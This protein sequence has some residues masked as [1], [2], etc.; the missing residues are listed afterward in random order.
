MQWFKD[1]LSNEK[2]FSASL[3]VSFVIHAA[4][5]LVFLQSGKVIVPANKPLV[6]DFSIGSKIHTYSRTYEKAAADMPKLNKQ[7]VR[8]SRPVPVPRTEEQAGHKQTMPVETN[9]IAAAPER[10]SREVVKKDA[11]HANAD[12]VKTAVVGT[13]TASGVNEARA[14]YLKEHFAYIRDLIMKSISYPRIARKMGW[15]GKVVVSFV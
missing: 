2:N 11:S 10:G 15:E 3:W 13:K 12:A 9:P 6:I 1:N 4:I 14:R 8:E 5:F 7:I